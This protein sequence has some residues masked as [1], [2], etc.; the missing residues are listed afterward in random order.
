M[1]DINDNIPY[2]PWFNSEIICENNF[3]FKTIN[4]IEELLKINEMLPNKSDYNYMN[5]EMLG[6]SFIY[7]DPALLKIINFSLLK[8]YFP[9]KLEDIGDKSCTEN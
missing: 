3:K 6:D 5:K 4:S 9:K 8:W 7:T 1:K 2:E